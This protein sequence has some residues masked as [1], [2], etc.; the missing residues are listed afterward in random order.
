MAQQMEKLFEILYI[1]EDDLT[2]LA[3]TYYNAKAET[4]EE[5]Q[6]K[7]ENYARKQ[8]LD[9]FSVLPAEELEAFNA[10]NQF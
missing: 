2:G 10:E 5:A 6:K 4:E 7:A 1:K 9:V 8:G 3:S